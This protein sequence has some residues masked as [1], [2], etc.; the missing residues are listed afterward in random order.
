MRSEFLIFGS[1]KIEEDEINEVVDSLRKCWL[2]TGP[3]VAQ[4]ENQFKEYVGAKHAVAVHSCTAAL[5]LSMIAS[6]IGPGDEVITT[7]MT[8]AATANSIIHTGGI[9]VFIDVNRDTMTIDVKQI[10]EKITTRTKAI[11]PVHFAGRACQMDEIIALANKYKLKIINDAA[12][13]IETD[14]HGKKVSNYGNLTTYSFYS[15]KNLAT[16]EGGMVTTDDGELA[17]KIKIYGLHGMTKDAW[18]RF[19]DTGYKHYE[20][21]YP[22]FK[23]NMMDMQAALG[24]HQLEKIERYSICRK[25]IWDRYNEAFAELPLFLPAAVEPNTRHAFHLYTILLDLSKVKITRDEF[26]NLLHRENIGTGVH[27]TALHLHPYYKERF[28]YKK[29]D[30][31]NTEFIGERTVSLPISAKLTD[32]DVEDVIGAVKNILHNNK[33]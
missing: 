31:P 13:A 24:I 14:Y 28:G 3:K 11:I 22:G 23:Y 20:I 30:F 16:G 27:Y 26:M 18:K 32:Q 17:E 19:S 12:H 2:G 1:P 25:E 6:D 8:F 10:E 7:P 33:K 9:P 4:F 15:T 5:H 21:I 29:G